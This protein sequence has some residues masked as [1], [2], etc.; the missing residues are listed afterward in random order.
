MKGNWITGGFKRER[1]LSS[2]ARNAI[3]SL[4]HYDAVDFNPYEVRSNP[5]AP[6]AT[7]ELQTPLSA[8][9]SALSREQDHSLLIKT[10]GYTTSNNHNTLGIFRKIDTFWHDTSISSDTA[11]TSHDI[12]SE[13]NQKYRDLIRQLPSKPHINII[14]QTFFNDVNWQYYV[15]D[16]IQFRQQ[17]DAWEQIPYAALSRG[18]Y[19]LNAESRAFPALVFQ[20]IAQALLHQP[21]HPD[22][23][24]ES[25]KY[26]AGMTFYD[27]ALEFSETG[28]AIL[29]I[30]GKRDAT[31]AMVQ[32]GLL[33][34]SFLK[35]SGS[36]IEAWHTLGV[37]I[38][39]AQE[40]GLHTSSVALDHISSSTLGSEVQAPDNIGLRPRVWL[41]LHIWDLHMAVVL[42]R[43]IAT[44][45]R[46]VTFPILGERPENNPPTALSVILVGYHAA[47]QY[48]AIVHELDNSGARLEQYSIVEEV[49]SKILGNIQSLPSWCRLENSSLDFDGN[50]GCLWLPA[51]RQGLSSLIHFVLLALHRPYI[52]SVAESRTQALKAA[53]AILRAQKQLFQMSQSQHCMTFN[54]VFA[55][56]DAIVLIVA[57][58]LLYPTENCEYLDQSLQ[59][60]EWG[61]E[62]LAIIG[63]EN[64]MANS[65][66]GVV[67][68]LHRR[69]KHRLAWPT[70]ATNQA[71]PD[72]SAGS[73][74][75]NDGFRL[76]SIGSRGRDDPMNSLPLNIDFN[77]IAPPHPTHALFYR[78]LASIETS[79]V[80]S[81]AQYQVAA[82]SLSTDEWHVS[83]AYLDDSFW[84]FMEDF[85]P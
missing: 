44:Q 28:A 66:H 79:T 67:L 78:N 53:L 24:L 7:C 85:D 34:A 73:V 15:I 41:V 8:T 68:G 83:G 55:S 13:L 71:V 29:S 50:P 11:E 80:N 74:G 77:A 18:L 36:V 43:P 63:K 82:S 64:K 62:T 39:D 30:L 12:P 31:M 21:S 81:P 84:N 1:G 65:A 54:L 10:L 56:F 35:S 40:I 45:F 27:L 52:F 72:G 14:L 3:D 59:H 46:P 6:E 70:P 33:R 19:G 17:I 38:R 51:A 75:N 42:G 60:I 48:L 4:C 5:T 16:E 69:L 26:A 37:A 32:A 25:L 9:E 2:L 49:H 23:R 57:I 22:E 47:Y 58:Y 61:V 76:L 20:V